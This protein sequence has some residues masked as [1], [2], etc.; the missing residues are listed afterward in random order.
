MLQPARICRLVRASSRLLVVAT[1]IGAIAMQDGLAADNS[2]A[3]HTTEDV[4]AG[5]DLVLPRRFEMAMSTLGGPQFW[6]DVAAFRDYRLQQNV[7]T[8]HFRL[9]DGKY[10]RLVSGT[11]EDCQ[12][13]LDE[14][15]ET[16]GVSPRSG[17]AVVLIHGI[18]RSSKSFARMADRLRE[19]GYSVYRFDYPSTQ[20]DIPTAA[21]SLN[22]F[23][24]SLDEAREI[25][26]VVHSMGGLVVRA[27]CQEYSDLR[28]GRLVMLGTPNHGAELA[29][30]LKT[31]PVYRFVM[32]PSGQQL[33]TGGLIA[34]LPTPA[35]EFAVIAGGRGDDQGWNPLIPG[36]DDGTVAV[37][38]ARL[39]GARVFTV[40]P[41][42]H[43]FLTSDRRVIEYTLRFLETGSIE[44]PAISP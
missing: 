11:R 32:G 18:T 13:K 40:V 24:S 34:T 30:K 33:V 14:L 10:R 42:I 22:Q 17:S 16:L 25:H 37:E 4:P 20:V 5:G 44:E 23:L 35:F 3:A 8:E 6:T 12:H 15:R 19:K 36:D 31:N 39:E 2:K 41:A 38:R 26:F 7:F 9:L 43:A 28:I 21:D 29:D 27:W 1:V